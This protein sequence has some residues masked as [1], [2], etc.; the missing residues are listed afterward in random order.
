MSE[1][2]RE[3]GM[4]ARYEIR[5]QGMK[6][7]HT[8]NIAVTSRREAADNARRSGWRY[9]RGAWYCVRC[10]NERRPNE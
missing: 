3:A 1:Y 5:C 6:C 2:T 9:I 4:I 10:A 7:P 8:S